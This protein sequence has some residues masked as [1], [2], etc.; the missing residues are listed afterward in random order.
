MSDAL[1]DLVTGFANRTL[2]EEEWTHEAHLRVGLWHVATL[3]AERALPA[4]RQQ[5]AALNESFGHQNTATSGYHE[6]ITAAYVLLTAR[7][8]ADWMQREENGAASMA[9]AADAIVH[10]PL[11]KRDVLLRYW[12]KDCLMSETARARW[13][14]PDIAPL[15][16]SPVETAS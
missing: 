7:W 14:E 2:R 6:T 5:I 10:S 11:A 3:G 15:I 13:V 8:Y 16:A 9:Q 4:L 12:S 1:N